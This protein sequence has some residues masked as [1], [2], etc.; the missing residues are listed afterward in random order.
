M[1]S[2]HMQNQHNFQTP[3]RTAQFYL[4]TAIWNNGRA[5]ETLTQTHKTQNRMLVGD[6]LKI[7]YSIFQSRERNYVGNTLKCLWGTDECAR[8]ESH[9]Q[10]RFCL[11]QIKFLRIYTYNL[12]EKSY[13]IA[14]ETKK[15]TWLFIGQAFMP[16]FS[17]G[18]YEPC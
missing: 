11:C 18:L 9:T 6:Q 2:A 3:S 14:S 12:L 8:S 5:F 1:P 4:L 17:D 13:Q 7:F 16:P 10:F 15:I